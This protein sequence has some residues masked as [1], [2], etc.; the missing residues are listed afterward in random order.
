M[1]VTENNQERV[2][3]DQ[4]SSSQGPT[5]V[6]SHHS[7]GMQGTHGGYTV[8]SN[9]CRERKDMQERIYFNNDPYRIYFL[10]IRLW[11]SKED[12]N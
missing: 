2:H 10:K 6:S 4:M 7:R 3:W 11:R 8:S 12:S 1:W 9:Q 5:G